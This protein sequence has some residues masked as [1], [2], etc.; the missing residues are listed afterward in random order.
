MRTLLKWVL[1]LVLLVVVLAGIA[2]VHV[3]YFKPL[4][5]D[6]F[7]GRVFGQFALQS[8]QMLSSMRILPPWAD[9][10]S[11]KLDDASPQHADEMAA[12]VKADLDMLH[13]YDRDALD[14]DGKLSYDALE[15]F[16]SDQVEG[17]RF[18]FHDFPVNQMFG[19]QSNL[20]NFMAQTHQVNNASDAENYIRRLD[21]VPEHFSQVIE[22]LR[23][24]ESRGVI[25]PK[26]TVD[27]VL[28]QMKAFIAVPAAE[29]MLYTSLKEKLDKLGTAAIDPTG[30]GELLARA[31]AS[32]DGK[33]Y[34]AY[35]DLIAYFTALQPK[36]TDN[37]G[38]WSL[39][40]GDAYYAWCVRSHTT[41]DMTPAQVHE[42]GLSEVARISAEMD[43]ILRDR[44]LV[45]GS[46][47]SRVQQLAREP[48][49]MYA[50]T[51]EGKEAMIA[52]YQ[53][54]LDDVNAN[55]GDAFNRRPK[56]GVEVKPV[57]A[58]SEKT[59]PGAY[60][61]GGAFDG[62]RPGVFFANL[63]DPGETPKF[64]MRTLAY[65]E[66]IPG[67]HFQI[68]I[69]QELQ[70]VPFF[71]RVL[72]FTA[73]SEG[74]A[75]Y[76]ERLA[77]E[78]GFEKDPLD[79]L[80][81]LRDEMMRAVRLV[82]DSGI[83]YKHWTREAAITYMLDNTGMGEGDV[84][85]EIERYFVNPGQA[86]AYKAGMLKIL[87][88]REKAKQELGDRFSLSEFHDEVLTHGALPLSLVERVI[89]DWIARRKAG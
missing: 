4:K 41:T 83:H 64:A 89:D 1:R 73:Y 88:L 68:T 11:D 67:H 84:T 81:R 85:A 45:D 87:A 39:P 43:A 72:P 5:I 21:R 58:F 74:W 71:R 78:M 10:Y 70:G 16:L 6:W 44:G 8:P 65:H 69:A 47:G 9:F 29:N 27:K 23:L 75:L 38:A 76:A 12:M 3:W 59:A 54:I 37:L 18:R 55:L 14:E 35:R 62:S 33:V 80:G 50:N 60:Y 7:Y 26:F 48:E 77:W 15:F 13:R 2:F 51:P 32:I 82:V 20:P 61:Q 19:V 34:P 63:R 42:L 17:A 30:Q 53:A 24:R 57:P 86:L 46:V 22:D 66:G 28:D 25:P 40:D 52:R 49:Q 31:Q 79:N 36:A 56:L